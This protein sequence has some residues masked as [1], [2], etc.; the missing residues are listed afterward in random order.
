M[1]FNFARAAAAGAAAA[2]ASQL[3]L[4][5]LC[6]EIAT[7]LTNPCTATGKIDDSNRFPFFRSA[8]SASLVDVVL[9]IAQIALSLTGFY[10]LALPGSVQARNFAATCTILFDVFAKILSIVNVPFL[11]IDCSFSQAVLSVFSVPSAHALA[12]VFLI[13]LVIVAVL[14][15]DSIRMLSRPS[16]SSF[17]I[18]LSK[19]R[20][21][22][23]SLV[24][25]ARVLALFL[26][27]CS[28]IGVG[29]SAQSL[30]IFPVV[31][32]RWHRAVI[33]SIFGKEQHCGF[34][35]N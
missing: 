34:I 14:N 32:R 11:A 22:L 24:V 25:L 18:L 7:I 19:L 8:I 16:F 29:V 28:V 21:C 26:S 3:G 31:L 12:N 27:M 13:L 9:S 15:F 5:L 20:I 6:C 1:Q 2:V 33:L 35:T 17:A 30:C 23:A 4:P 10:F